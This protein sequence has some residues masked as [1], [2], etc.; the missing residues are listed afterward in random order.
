MATY[1]SDSPIETADCDRYGIAPFAEAIARSI[2]GIEKP[3][4]T[5]IAIHGPW[6]AGKSSAVN[7]MRAALARKPDA[8]LLVTDFR[9]WWYRGEDALALAFLQHIYDLLHDSLSDTVKKL[10]PNIA[11]R[12]LQGA[13]VVGHAVA[14]MTGV[15]MGAAA[16][17][18]ANFAE[19]F[20]GDGESIEVMFNKLAAAL[21][22]QHRR[23]LVVIDDI[24]RLNP[25]ETLAIFRLVKSVGRL[26]NVMYLLV[27]D[28]QLAEKIV[29]E[30]FPAEGPQ[31]LE[32]I[33]Q[34]GFDLP[35][36]AQSDL[37]ESV[38][39][40][41]NNICGDSADDQNTR[42]AN[43]FLDVVAPYMTTPRH[44]IRYRNAI[45][46]TWPA[47]AGEVD[48][49]DF[50]ALEAIRLYEP[51]LFNAIRS[52]V[53]QL[54]GDFD[55]SFDPDKRFERFLAD[56]REDRKYVA[57][58]ALIRLFPRMENTRYGSDWNDTWSRERRVCAP[59]HFATYF[60]L[61][62][63]D[64]S[65]SMQSIDALVARAGETDFV[66]AELR[67]AANT[68]RRNGQTMVPVYFD[69][70]RRHA[71]RIAKGDIRPFLAALFEVF[72]DI[73]RTEDDGRG[74]YNHVDTRIRLHRLLRKATE[75][76]FSI[77]ER[78]ELY[79]A[80]SEGAALGWLVDFADTARSRHQKRPNRPMI[81]EDEQLVEEAA[82]P[83]FVARAL[84]AIRSA[85]GDG[86][87]IRHRH[88]DNLLFSWRSLS[89]HEPN[90]VRIWADSL[91][92]D[93]DLVIMLARAWTGQ[94][95]SLAMGGHGGLGD[96]VA[97]ATPRV[98]IS[99]ATDLVNVDRLAA[100][101]AR[102]RDAPDSSDDATAAA[103]IFLEAWARR[104]RGEED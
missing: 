60:R 59:E 58:N 72:D 45:S 83:K 96:R 30:R 2:L 36:P 68:R 52:G 65:L 86:S 88:L 85:A 78:T 70:L 10:I 63:G 74:F 101:L 62:L 69:E 87:L 19:K 103:R 98:R 51:G 94:S 61:S 24:D 104:E 39:A 80:A 92:D 84:T 21:D 93:D 15:P 66:Q 18:A 97:K 57:K 54:C 11:K 42:A 53:N 34:A 31:F 9:C 38:V 37:N 16:G 1:H 17:A 95:W 67:Q 12:L 29:S 89:P 73:D 47:V 35:L 3:V 100:T 99:Q 7:L 8:N 6:G 33:I 20:F 71:Q 48:V 75:D 81:A 91:L 23:F 64:D 13:P 79:W 90:E 26:P 55:S 4:G 82:V 44:A 56:V 46:V 25:E 40:D 49:G 77:Y 32:K 14:V 27:F 5:T 50:I 43:L 22:I 41:I 76:R 102:I 28:R